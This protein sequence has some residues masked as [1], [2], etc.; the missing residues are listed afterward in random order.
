MYVFVL[1]LSQVK[2]CEVFHT[3]KTI[4]LILDEPNLPPL[5]LQKA[6]KSILV[7]IPFQFAFFLRLPPLPIRFALST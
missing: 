6:Q 4:L 7:K 3:S 1:N 2:L 5:L